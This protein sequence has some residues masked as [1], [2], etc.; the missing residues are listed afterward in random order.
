[1]TSVKSPTEMPY[2][3][4]ILKAV[5]EYTLALDEYETSLKTNDPNNK[6]LGLKKPQIERIARS[7]GLV[8]TT[9]SRR[10]AGKTQARNEAHSKEQKLT[11]EEEQALEEWT[12]QTSAWGWPPRVSRLRHMAID[13]LR[14]RNNYDEL[15]LNWV[16]KFLQRHPK[17]TGRFSQPL[18]KERALSHDPS[19]VNGW[20]KLY[21]D[22]VQRYNI[23]RADIYNMDEKGFA[24]GLAGRVKVICPKYDLKAYMN[25]CGNRE[26]VSLIECISLDG[27]LLNPYIIF[28]GK[29]HLK[30]WY[31]D[32]LQKG[33]TIAL[34]DNGWTNNILGLHWFKECFDPLTKASLQGTHRLLIYDGHASHIN[35]DVI[36]YCTKNNIILL[37][38][39]AHTTHFLQPLDVGFFSPLAN[40]YRKH[41]EN[42]TRFGAD[43]TIDKTDFIRLYQKARIEAAT[44]KNIAHSWM[45]AGLSPL[46]PSLIFQLSI[47]DHLRQRPKTPPKLLH[48]ETEFTVL[49]TP[50]NPSEIQALIQKSNDPASEVTQKLAKAAT[51]AMTRGQVL[52]VVNEELQEA[53]KRKKIKAARNNAHWGEAQVMNMEV[54]MQRRK[55]AAEIRLDRELK[56]L[57]RLGPDLWED[58]RQLERDKEYEKILK[59]L[60]RLGPDLLQNPKSPKSPVKRVPPLVLTP[61]SPKVT[62]ISLIK[63]QRAQEQSRR[64]GQQRQQQVLKSGGVEGMKKEGSGSEQVVVTRSGRTVKPSSRR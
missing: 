40:Y 58:K 20:F 30:V 15:G 18:D 36:S 1:M 8:S 6:S 55:A 12:I 64:Q 21:A 60:N 48:T 53:V 61:P 41:L 33:G 54:V 9:L 51:L 34:S 32:C 24:I 19:M 4:R 59:A 3:Q 43:Y 63:Q 52:K 22:T 5:A 45:N 23:Q 42:F 46:N 28:K 57:Y 13:I 2:E 47:F 50:R 16:E 17:L 11:W 31:D 49:R 29:V 44:E 10:I 26:W 62:A 14:F 38:L 7:H 27:R 56:A 35:S 25:Q 37:C 39:P